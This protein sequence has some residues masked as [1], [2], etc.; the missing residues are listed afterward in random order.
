MIG[1]ARLSSQAWEGSGYNLSASELARGLALSGHAVSYLASGMTYYLLRR[2]RIRA[3]ERWGGVDCYEFINSPNLSPSAHN[4]RNVR[5]EV[6]CPRQT[7]LVMRWLEQVRAQVVHIHSLEGYALDLVRA[8][9]DSGRPVVVTPHNYWFVCPQVDLLHREARVCEDYDGG[10]R[11]EG[12]LEAPRPRVLK[13][14][15]AVGDTLERWLG[16]YRADIL[17]K[18]VYGVGPTLRAIRTGAAFRPWKPPALNPDSLDD[19]ELALGF[20]AGIPP[21]PEGGVD[22]GGALDGPAVEPC[23][24]DQNARILGAPHHLTV[25][26]DYGRRRVAGVEALNLASLV[27]SP[28]DFLRRV[29]VAMGVDSHRVRW[30]RLGQPH[31]DRINRR[32]RRSPYYD[33]SPWH[34][35]T[36]T[37]PLRFAYFGTTRPNKGLEVL[38]RAIPLIPAALRRQCQVIIRALGDDAG[39]RRR[40]AGYPEVSVSGAYD[41]TQLVAA[42]GEYDVGILPHIWLENSPLVMLEHLHAGKFVIASRLGGPPDWIYPPRNGLLFTAGRSEEL[43]RCMARVLAGEVVLPSPREVHEAT[44]LQSYPA[45]VREVESIYYEV[46]SRPEPVGQEPEARGGALASAATDG[47]TAGSAVAAAPSGRRVGG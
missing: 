42:A 35:S 27:I 11:C 41:L 24:P 26:N 1:W 13:F 22:A 25:L 4:F 45:H 14:K 18:A 33:V 28:S 38:V 43:A 23:A 17:R 47:W 20:A 3:R 5:T 19:P 12:C 46:L 39:V 6:S 30:V 31:F 10:R 2:P 32:A 15:R 34:P 37:R 7:R 8:I 21:P 44:A 40:L 36:A 29:H 9:R 16:P